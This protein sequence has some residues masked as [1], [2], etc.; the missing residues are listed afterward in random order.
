ME[1][2][3]YE[4]SIKRYYINVIFTILVMLTGLSVLNP[5]MGLDEMGFLIHALLVMI[6]SVC[7]IYYPKNRTR[8]FRLCIVL[9]SFALFYL[10]FFLY[11]E[12]GT[13][14]LL[15]CF[16]PAI[17]ILFFDAKLFYF[18]IILNTLLLTLTV[19]Y[20]QLGHLEAMYPYLTEDLIGNCINL[21]VSQIILSFIF[22][23][24]SERIRAQHLF[25][26]QMKHNERLK[27]TGELAAAVA[28]EIRNPLT[29]VKGYLQ[30]YEQDS[31]GDNQK[32]QNFRLLIEELETAEHVITD[33]LSLS[34]PSNNREV[35]KIEIKP[36][37][38]NVAELLQSYGLST[39]NKID[40]YVEDDCTIIMNKI[41]L[42]QLL[43]NIIKNAIEASSSGDSIV[44]RAVKKTEN[45]VITV[46]DYGKGMSA[47]ELESIGTPFY[48]LKAKGTGLGIMICN[49]I[50]ANNNGSIHYE[51]VSGKGTTVTI[52]FPSH[53]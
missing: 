50:V 35:E 10:L 24:T 14:I 46:S 32:K 19:T 7:L 31:A 29:V 45:V 47:Q 30:I 6:L 33:L 38:Y 49:H 21:I 27:T 28:H 37:I 4:R 42:H 40:A 53:H 15:I 13:T 5:R 22:H 51:S 36:I 26:E 9:L 25:Y 12:T 2:L 11:P 8:Y 39:K 48:S 52:T 23:L 41:E 20:I 3:L 16:I 44:V 34:K 43:V 18:S 1:K 17:S